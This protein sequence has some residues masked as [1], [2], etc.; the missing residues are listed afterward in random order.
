MFWTTFW[1]ITSLV[2]YIA[3]IVLVV[4]TCLFLFLN[5]QDPVKTISWML[6]LILLPY[7]GIIFYLFLGRNFRKEKMFSRKGAADQKIRENICKEMIQSVEENQDFI[8]ED[9]YPYRKLIVQN[10]RASSSIL[11]TNSEVEIYF[12]GEAALDAM[13]EAISKAKSSIHL[14]TFIIEDDKTGAEFKDLL[15]KKARQG[16]EVRLMFDGFGGRKIPKAFLKEMRDASVEVLNFSPFRWIL[17]KL[18]INYRNHRKILVVDGSIGFLGGVNIAD[19]YY[20]GG[21]FPEWR[22]THVKLVGESVYSL[23]SSFILDR[24]FI[25][26]KNLRSREKYYPD[27]NIQSIKEIEDI[28]NYYHSQIISS[29]PDSD[30]SGIAQCFFTAIT[31]AK[32]HIYIITPYFIPT[33]SILSAVKITALSD[34]EVSLMIP[35]KS[36]NWLSNWATRSYITELLNAGVKIYLFKKG[37][38]HSKVLSID[39]KFCIIGSANM[40][41]RSLEHHFEVTSILYNEGCAKKIEDQFHRDL[42]RCTLITKGRWK[43]RKKRY[44]IYES[45]ARLLSPLL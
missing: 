15:I 5:K 7:V 20:D 42:D 25:I 38:N 12:T 45:I 44:R 21:V 23:Q 33:E 19:R 34:V 41:I 32:N 13:K 27:F 9:L 37:F 6:V 10:L 17:P 1:Q 8:P 4:I 3:N 31:E 36:D 29:G 24:F 22:D 14:Q 16:I 40:D 18:I 11:T 26:N 39:G 35:E 2:L 30:W 43:K 28:P